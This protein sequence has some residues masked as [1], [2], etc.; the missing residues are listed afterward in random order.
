[1]KPGG[2]LTRPWL[3]WSRR[4]VLLALLV[5]LALLAFA[6]WLRWT[7]NLHPLIGQRYYRSA[8]LDAAGWENAYKTYHIRSVLNLRGANAGQPWYDEEVRLAQQNHVVHYDFR[9]SA[10]QRLSPDQIDRV[11]ALLKQ[12]PKPVLIHCQAGADRT[13]LISAIL[14]LKQ[15]D[16]PEQARQ[17]LSLRYGHFP[18]LGS[19]TIAMNQS[20]DA[21]L[22]ARGAVAVAQPQPAGLQ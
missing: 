14:R 13:G 22:Q 21:Y 18:Y 6:G 19:S 10:G 4:L 17:Q 15:G 11:V 8:Q 7:G 16:S 2:A 12:A 3:K 9:M 5:F 1:M 20:F